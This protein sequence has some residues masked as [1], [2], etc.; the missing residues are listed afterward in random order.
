MLPKNETITAHMSDI[1]QNENYEEVIAGIDPAAKLLVI[2]GDW[3]QCHKNKRPSKGRI[4]GLPK[5]DN[6]FGEKVQ[7]WA[8]EAAAYIN[9][10]T[11]IEKGNKVD[12]DKIPKGEFRKDRENYGVMYK[13]MNEVL[14]DTE[15]R[16]GRISEAMYKKNKETGLE[17]VFFPGHDNAYDFWMEKLFPDLTGGY[18]KTLKTAAQWVQEGGIIDEGTDMRDSRYNSGPHFRFTDNVETLLIEGK[19][20]GIVVAPLTVLPEASKT[21]DEY[22]GVDKD[23]TEINYIS[24][25]AE[26]EKRGVL[27]RKKFREMLG[28]KP[29]IL[30]AS[31]EGPKEVSDI[32]LGHEGEEGKATENRAMFEAMFLEQNET[33]T[34]VLWLYG[35]DGLPVPVTQHIVYGYGKVP[36]IAHHLAELDEKGNPQSRKGGVT[37]VSHETGKIYAPRDY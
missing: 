24:G 10:E 36:I 31:H 37:Y 15:E 23:L 25:K 20:S 4:K 26:Y 14:K 1:H 16:L 6:G 7:G 35:N 21:L 22:F 11:P 17:M 28:E 2:H 5:F 8:L 9:H 19:E 12:F 29:V 13:F 34:K 27:L 3:L 18:V 32:V 30:L 33:D